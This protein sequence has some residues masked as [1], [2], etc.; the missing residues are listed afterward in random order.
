M[1]ERRS[2]ENEMSDLGIAAD[3]AREFEALGGGGKLPLLL[4]GPIVRRAT[5]RKVW[6]WFACSRNV[7]ACQAS[8]VVYDAMAPYPPPKA[9][10][11]RREVALKPSEL[12]VVRAGEAL[13][14]VLVAAEPREGTLPTDMVV[15]YDLAISTEGAGTTKL[16]SLGL[17]IAY[18]PYALPTFLVAERNHNLVHGSCRRPGADAEDATH[19]YDEW[20]A[21]R[22]HMNFARPASLFLTGDQIYADDVAIR[23]FESVRRLAADIFGYAEQMPEASGSGLKSA[24]SYSWTVPAPT[25]GAGAGSRAP[26]AP[27]KSDRKQLTAIGTS[28][29]GFTTDDGEAH[30]L[31][32]A[33]YAAMYLMVWNPELCT[34]YGVEGGKEPGLRN[35]ARAT[36][37]CRRVMA[38]TAT[39]MVCDDHEITDDWNLDAAWET[40]TKRNPLAR[41]IISNALAAFWGFQ[42][43]GNDPA[44]FDKAFVQAV[45][46]FWEQLRV[47]KGQPRTLH[48]RSPYNAAAAYE[49][50]LLGRHWSFIAPS[51]PFALCVDT[52]T[53]REY[54]K[55]ETAILSGKRVW[56]HIDRLLRAQG[57][58]K[59]APLL[60]VLPTSLLP[61]R[62]MMYIQGKE[63]DWPKQRYQGDYELYGNNS[64]QRAE[65]VLHLQAVFDPSSLVIFSGDVHH[66]SVVTG[67]YAYGAK[68]ADI[69]KGKANWVMR[70]VQITSS[71]IKNEKKAAYV[72]KRWWTAWQTD[73]G[74][75][76]ESVVSQ[77]ENQYAPISNGAYIA[78]QAMVRDMKG[79]LGRQTYIFEP[80]LCVV[81]MPKKARDDAAITF[82]GVKGGKLATAEVKVDTRN[83]P[84]DFRVKPLPLGKTMPAQ[85]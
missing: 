10:P 37:A 71:P 7:T 45:T 25:P 31:S 69:R 80:H 4:A 8:F 9:E 66:G 59:G 76:G 12:Q 85:P 43:W 82:V 14:L 33:E 83:D 55:G 46:L 1:L 73:A 23:L 41:R 61:H 17:G 84:S 51:Q 79:P 58:Q 50:A 57:F 11:K 68:L 53:L 39:Y 27:T 81:D 29:I 78:M 32:F 56:P 74:N 34:R 38:N 62:S 20:L 16:S 48:S 24:D 75:V 40:A 21:A 13:W 77:W 67:R 18:A 54:P 28:P 15:G 72:K 26:A 47:S 42:A 49:K 64:R 70:I 22:A 3:S 60:L 35:F 2:F 30:L 19:I 65:L 6:F 36:R 52:R 44:A 5:A 63:Y